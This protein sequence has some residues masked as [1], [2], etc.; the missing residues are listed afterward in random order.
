MWLHGTLIKIPATAPQWCMLSAIII[1]RKLVCA[2]LVSGAAPRCDIINYLRAPYI[3]QRPSARAAH[4]R[5][6]KT[7]SLRFSHFSGAKR[8]ICAS[9][10]R[11][12]DEKIPSTAAVHRDIIYRAHCV[13]VK[14]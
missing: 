7:F 2:L 3:L 5:A 1:K 4:T 14:G 9:G 13:M 11:E 6:D 12:R 8:I 10:E